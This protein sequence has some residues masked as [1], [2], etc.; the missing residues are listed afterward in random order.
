MDSEPVRIPH[1]QAK[2][3][4]LGQLILNVRPAFAPQV[5]DEASRPLKVSCREEQLRRPS[6]FC[7]QLGQQRFEPPPPFSA[8][9][10]CAPPQSF[11][12]ELND[13]LPQVRLAPVVGL[14]PRP[15]L[16]LLLEEIR[17][18]AARTPRT[19]LQPAL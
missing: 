7:V 4:L 6:P 15:P 9:T 5:R 14:L 3:Q 17:E 1:I 12:C 2:T 8:S 18:V 11:R 13:D 19:L 16:L 10:Q